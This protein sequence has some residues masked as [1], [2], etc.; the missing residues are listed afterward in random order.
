MRKIKNIIVH[1]SDSPFGCASLIREWHLARGWKDVGYHA[2]ILNSRPV[3]GLAF[4]S[5]N[6]SVEIGRKFDEDL[7]I[8]A[9]EVGAHALGYNDSSLG[10]CLIGKKQFTHEQIAKLL[11]LLNDLIRQYE[12]SPDAVIG[13]YETESGKA[14]GKTCP[15]I[16]MD[17]IRKSLDSWYPFNKPIGPHGAPG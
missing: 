17:N 8:E 11:W 6:G 9:D 15:N 13:H 10:I 16:D 12:L 14:Q 5:I 3:N 2:V 7:F 1:C 4:N